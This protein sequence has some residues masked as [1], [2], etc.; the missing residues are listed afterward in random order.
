VHLLN[1]ELTQL[2][3]LWVAVKKRPSHP[4]FMSLCFL[5]DQVC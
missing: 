5:C 1:G 2:P 4:F 3:T